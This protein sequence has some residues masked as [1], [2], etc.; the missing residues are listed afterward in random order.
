MY[1]R[2]GQLQI[3][4]VNLLMLV[5]FSVHFLANANYEFVMYIGVIVFFLIVFISTNSKVYYPNGLLWALT[6]WALMHLSGGALYFYD[7]RLYDIIIIPLSEKLPILR[8]DQIVHIFGFG[9]A[10]ALMFYILKPL[11]K[12][13]LNGYWSLSIVVIMAGLGV[14][15]INEIVEFFTSLIVPESGVGGYINTSLDLAADLIGAIIAMF[16]IRIAERD[17]FTN[18][19]L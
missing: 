5:L 11:L 16:V 12:P 8:Y 17:F 4:I 1:S 15:A 19:L 10:T 6:A 18:S 2:K 3:M 13:K 7:V 14:G 9:T